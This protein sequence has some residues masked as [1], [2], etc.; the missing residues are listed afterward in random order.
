MQMETRQKSMATAAR[1]ILELA[2]RYGKVKSIEEGATPRSGKHNYLIT[3]AREDEAEKA[4][5]GLRGKHW[6][7]YVVLTGR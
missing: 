3:Y 6:G 4:S 2:R 7:V 1:G 5:A